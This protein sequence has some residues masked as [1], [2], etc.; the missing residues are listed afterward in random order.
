MQNL[1]LDEWFLLQ[2]LGNIIEGKIFK[3]I[4]NEDREVA[5]WIF[6]EKKALFREKSKCKDL[7]RE[8]CSVYVSNIKE[9]CVLGINE[10]G[11]SSWRSSQRDWSQDGAAY[12]KDLVFQGDLKVDSLGKI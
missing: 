1:R 10:K 9:S 4:F 2:F 8:I 3:E 12:L 6:K 5:I 7:R 11:R